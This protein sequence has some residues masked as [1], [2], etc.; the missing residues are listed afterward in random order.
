MTASRSCSGAWPIELA[1]P[2]TER[3]RD[4]AR[5][6]QMLALLGMVNYTPQW[7]RPEGRFTPVQIADAYCD[8]FFA[9]LGVDDD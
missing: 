4:D 5:R 9:A 7:Y 2:S 6:L 3:N 1:P 8:M